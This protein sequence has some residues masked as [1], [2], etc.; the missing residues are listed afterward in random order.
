MADRARQ[1]TSQPSAGEL[2]AQERVILEHLERQRT[3]REISESTG[4][5]L[6]AVRASIRSVLRKVKPT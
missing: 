3:G 4:I 2:T 1:A 6:D 5:P